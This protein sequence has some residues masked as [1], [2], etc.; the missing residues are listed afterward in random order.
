[1]YR[2]LCSTGLQFCISHVSAHPDSSRVSCD[3]DHNYTPGDR[4]INNL[5]SIIETGEE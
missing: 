4:G 2:R 5:Y 1:M 3:I